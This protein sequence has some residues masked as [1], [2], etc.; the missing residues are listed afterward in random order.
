MCARPAS[1]LWAAGFRDV[2]RPW[3]CACGDA[4]PMGQPGGACFSPPSHRT[5]RLRAEPRVQFWRTADS[6]VITPDPVELVVGPD[7][8]ARRA[9]RLPPPT[10]YT[11]RSSRTASF[12]APLPTLHSTKP[13]YFPAE[14]TR[15]P[16][17]N[18]RACNTRYLPLQCCCMSAHYQPQE[19]K[20]ADYIYYMGVIQRTCA[21]I[22]TRRARGAPSPR[23]ARAQP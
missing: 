20:S 7:A 3:A 15:R 16:G 13:R 17:R 5:S 12:T 9:T 23:A 2:C 8:G 18:A 6:L 11:L 19:G 22:S 14:V 1:E 4:H 10:A 21:C